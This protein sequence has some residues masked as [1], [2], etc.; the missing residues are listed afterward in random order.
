[1]LAGFSESDARI[2]SESAGHLEVTMVIY[3]FSWRQP[4][5]GIILCSLDP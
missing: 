4:L 2:T 1:M 5:S 3:S